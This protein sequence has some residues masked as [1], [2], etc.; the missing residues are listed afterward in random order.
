[1]DKLEPENRPIHE[2]GTTTSGQGNLKARKIVYYILGV[3]E[4]LFAFRLVFKL[5]GANPQSPFVSFIYTVSQAFLS[6]FSGIF[7]S[8]TT[9][10]IETQSVLES[11]TI[12]AM[13]VYA[14]VAWGIAKLIEISKSSK[15]TQI[16]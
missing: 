11:T 12:I 14:V 16:Q 5:L 1:M 8:A 3:L 4:V 9:K 15:N 13:I 6:P 7:R 10:G 2:G